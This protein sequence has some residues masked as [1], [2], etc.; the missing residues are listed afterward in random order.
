MVVSFQLYTFQ[1]AEFPFLNHEQDSFKFKIWHE[2]ARGFHTLCGIEIEK[3]MMECLRH[4]SP[5]PPLHNAKCD[6]CK[7]VFLVNVV[8]E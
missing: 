5:D 7:C 8:V 2:Q 1:S 3:L 4:K 6:K